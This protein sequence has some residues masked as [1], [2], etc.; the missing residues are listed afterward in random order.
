[1]KLNLKK[2]KD[3]RIGVLI[4]VQNMYYSARNLYGTHVDFQKILETAVGERQLIRAI[5]YVISA[6]NSEE[7]KFFDALLRIGFEVKQKDLQ[8][9]VGGT[10]KGDWDVGMAIDA[11]KMASNLD[12]IVLVTGDGDFIPLVEY[13]QFTGLMVEV[14][15]FRDTTSSRL[16][17][18]A[19]SFIDLG[20]EIGEYLMN[21]SKKKEDNG[22]NVKT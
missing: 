13:L 10:K 12:V 22:L 8:S 19:D 2:H 6:D 5:A 4:D 3:Q 21:K 18:S 1:M 7:Q 14:I 11:I 20:H 16:I 15:A 9:Y 17:E